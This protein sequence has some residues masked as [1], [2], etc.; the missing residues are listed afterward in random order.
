MGAALAARL[1]CPFIE[2][3]AIVHQPGW[4]VLPDDQLRARFA[5]LI[6]ADAWVCDG[7]YAAVQHLLL[8]RATDLVWLDAP[9]A[10]A[11]WQVFARSVARALLRRELYNGNRDRERQLLDDP[12]RRVPSTAALCFE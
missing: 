3:D 9:K 11:L 4:T 5:E 1:G 10:V 7:N 12:A 8:G 6:A 2:L